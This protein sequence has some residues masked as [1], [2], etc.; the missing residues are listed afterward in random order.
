MADL[1]ERSDQGRIPGP[2]PGGGA[3]GAPVTDWGG[4]EDGHRLRR[5]MSDHKVAAVVD[6][7][8]AKA[9]QWIVTAIALPALAWAAVS[10]SNRL[11]SIETALNAQVT[12]AA[13][14]EL[15]LQQVERSNVD[16]DAALR[17]LTEKSVLNGYRVDRLESGQGILPHPGATRRER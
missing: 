14:Q 3:S 15:R 2:P 10:V 17:L 8:Y 6:S 5:R 13:T 16:R 1:R 9:F 4:I 12:T 11:T 7:L